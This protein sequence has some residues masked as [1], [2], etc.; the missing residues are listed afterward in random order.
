M[1]LSVFL[2]MLNLDTL[3]SSI[4]LK[5]VTIILISILGRFFSNG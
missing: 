5:A 2:I 4:I 1:M 3:T